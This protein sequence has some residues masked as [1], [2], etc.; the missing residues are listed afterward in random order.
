MRLPPPAFAHLLRISDDAGVFEHAKLTVPRPEHGYCT[1]DVA[2]A[3][4]AV[5][6]ESCRPPEL[7][8]LVATCLA[9]L[10]RA[11]LPDGRFHNRLS[12][13]RRWLDEVGADDTVGRALW[14]LGVVSAGAT[15]R[16]QR[17]RARALFEA[18]AGFRTSW[19]RANAFAVLG[20]VELVG[21]R[22]RRAVGRAWELLEAAAAG[23]GRLSADPDW[24]WPEARLAYANAVLPEARLAAGVA[25]GE[26][27]LVADALDL[28]A[29]LVEAETSGEHFSFTPVG[30]GA[31]GSPRPGF[32]QQPIEAAAMADACARAF[33]V[34]GDPRWAVLSLRA[35]AWFLGANDVGVALL[36]AVSGG[37]KD[38]LMADGANENQGAESTLAL[39][40]ALQQARWLQA[41]ARRAPTTSAVTTLAA[42]TQR[43]AAP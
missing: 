15:M 2:R 34:T 12:V 9:F 21:A 27:R 7:E 31:P 11:L 17:E 40:T 22:P 30:G 19:P 37:C 14:A 20:A 24:P 10:E 28:L 32:D 16:E 41:A 42:P 33:A 26:D 6:R 43:S 1:D 8:R 18:G 38:G 35:A 29:W 23:L 39:I 25:L 36:D 3:L 4:V 5:M 13:R